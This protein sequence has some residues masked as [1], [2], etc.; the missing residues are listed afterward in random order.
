[1]GGGKFQKTAG[2]A[3]GTLPAPQAFE[4]VLICLVVQTLTLVSLEGGDRVW[5]VQNTVETRAVRETLF[6]C[7]SYP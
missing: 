7:F 2:A 4:R 3:L 5:F 1:M 6:S